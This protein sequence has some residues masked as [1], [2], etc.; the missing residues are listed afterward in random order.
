MIFFVYI[1]CF[2]SG[3]YQNLNDVQ[4]YV[5]TIEPPFVREDLFL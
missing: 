5:K 3:I 1:H 4:N 2:S